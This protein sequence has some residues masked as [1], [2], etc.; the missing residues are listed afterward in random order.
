MPNQ[1]TIVYLPP[2]LVRE[3]DE[4]A[5]GK[6]KISRNEAMR[7]GLRLL[8]EKESSVSANAFGLWK[9]ARRTRKQLIDA[10]R[11]RW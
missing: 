5:R 10:L 9:P 3:V 4:L 11:N 6:L 2:E 7:R 1:R 8:L